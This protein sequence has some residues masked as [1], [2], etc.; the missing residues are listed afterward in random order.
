MPQQHDEIK[1]PKCAAKGCPNLRYDGGAFCLSCITARR[2][3][4]C[5]TCDNIAAVQDAPA[6]Y[7][8]IIAKDAA[9][10]AAA[11][12][13]LVGAIDELLMAV[14]LGGID[15]AAAARRNMDAARAQLISTA[16]RDGRRIGHIEGIR[17]ATHAIA[18][19]TF[20]A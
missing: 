18:R 19:M 10:V 1:A 13:M 5:I 20:H 4:T 16:F 9:T 14:R 7:V 17:D 3:G 11:E 8:E 12:S 6:A 15:L 2:T